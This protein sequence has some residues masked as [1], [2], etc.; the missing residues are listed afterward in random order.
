MK[1]NFASNIIII[2]DNKYLLQLRSGGAKVKEKNTWGLFGGHCKLNEKSE[3][4]VC[5]ELKEETNL[6]IKKPKF[7][8]R[9]FV[10]EFQADVCVF[11]KKIKK[12]D[13]FQLNEGVDYNFFTKQEILN[14]STLD[15]KNLKPFFYSTV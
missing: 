14:K 4:C 8:F 1:K 6:R 7:L 11:S 13:N 2:K 15:K 9:F 10:K 5:R 3:K 12:I